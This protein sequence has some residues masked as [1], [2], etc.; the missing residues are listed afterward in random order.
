[1][2]RPT[3]DGPHASKR[4]KARSNTTL[5]WQETEELRRENAQR[6]KRL[7]SQRARFGRLKGDLR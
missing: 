5:S 1:M 2:A 3:E 7:G 6:R 4:R